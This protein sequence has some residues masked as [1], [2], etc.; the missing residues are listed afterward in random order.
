M[1]KSL[2]PFTSLQYFSSFQV[3]SKGFEFCDTRI[4]VDNIFFSLEYMYGNPFPDL[5]VYILLGKINSRA[6][7]FMLEQDADLFVMGSSFQVPASR[8]D[9]SSCLLVKKKTYRL[10]NV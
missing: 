1:D 7:T 9:D 6:R 2:S 3:P 8:S 4:C 10:K 5:N